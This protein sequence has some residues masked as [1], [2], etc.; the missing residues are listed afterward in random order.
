MNVDDRE[1]PD[2]MTL[3]ERWAYDRLLAGKPA[4]MLEYSHQLDGENPELGA[5]SATLITADGIIEAVNETSWADHQFLSA[6]F[7]ERVCID[8]AL[9]GPMQRSQIDIRNARFREHI[10]LSNEEVSGSLSLY[11]CR[12]DKGIFLLDTYFR[13]SLNFQGTHI[14]SNEYGYAL[15]GGRINTTGFVLLRRQGLY[16][17]SVQLTSGNIHGSVQLTGSRF[18]G[19]LDMS[20]IFIR[21]DLVLDDSLMRRPKPQWTKASSLSLKNAKIGALQ[22]SYSS[23]L[24]DGT[25]IPKNLDGFDCDRLSGGFGGESLEHA[26]GK[27]ILS[28][29]SDGV[30]LQSNDQKFS[31]TKYKTIA[32]A[33]KSAGY[34]SKAAIVRIALERDRTKNL[35]LLNPWKWLRRLVIGPTTAYGY[36]P[37]LGVFWFLTIVF[38]FAFMGLFWSRLFL[39]DEGADLWTN[40]RAWFGFSLETAFPIFELDPVKD[41]FLEEQFINHDSI[42]QQ[43]KVPNYVR[44]VFM[45]ERIIGILLLSTLVASIAGWAEKKG[46]E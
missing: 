18:D 22:S 44:A 40:F 46:N 5:R 32:K 4:I 24:I 2:W 29:L 13:G 16:E 41:N 26:S 35:P 33:L 39:F 3:Q 25:P 1:I 42:S 30:V 11:D 9:R 7:L 37:Y 38:L 28:W 10:D 43:N 36:K 34:D 23:W 31:P 14:C 20:S 21:D 6:R 45:I 17:G 27:Q 19:P 15:Q 12:L 8:K